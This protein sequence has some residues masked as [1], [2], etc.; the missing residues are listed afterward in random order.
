MQSQLEA[1][2]SA[3]LDKV[4]RLI[5]AIDFGMLTTQA[6]DGSLHSRPMSAN[7]EVGPNGELYFF[8]YG[9]SYKVF[10]AVEH[11]QCNVSFSDIKNNSY[12]SVS[13]IA[14]LVRDKALMAHLWKPELK[15]WFPQGLETQDIALLQ[16]TPERAEYWDGPSSAVAQT[17]SFLGALTGVE[18]KIGENKKVTL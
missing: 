11:P 18:V 7:G 2:K 5:K 6:E 10:E 12:V 9:Q 3:V 14:R 1:E 8:T 13:G 17:I 4:T 16:V 15:A